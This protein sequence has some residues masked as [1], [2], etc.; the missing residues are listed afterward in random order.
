MTGL[1]TKFILKS[2]H[3]WRRVL[4]RLTGQA[5]RDISAHYCCTIPV[6]GAGYPTDFYH[7]V[8]PAGY[9]VNYLSTHYPGQIF[10]ARRLEGDYQYHLRLYCDGTVTGHYEW[11]Y[12]FEMLKH[13]RGINC[14]PLYRDEIR[15]LETLLSAGEK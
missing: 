10:T 7:R 12:E 4:N 5:S 14:R 9:Q 15:Q 1:K 8:I 13:I 6:S 11:N 2:F 3:L